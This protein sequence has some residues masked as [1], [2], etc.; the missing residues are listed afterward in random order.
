[1]KNSRLLGSVDERRDLGSSDEG[2]KSALVGRSTGD[3]Q[4]QRQ[5]RWKARPG[6]L[7]QWK[8]MEGEKR[9]RSEPLLWPAK[10]HGSI[11]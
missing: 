11:G 7:S 4:R 3:R 5:R 2:E 9:L 8:G 10:N 6:P 1:V